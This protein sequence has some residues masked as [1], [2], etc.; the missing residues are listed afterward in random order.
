LNHCITQPLTTRATLRPVRSRFGR[1]EQFGAEKSLD[2]E[3]ERSDFYVLEIF[4][5]G[6]SK[7]SKIYFQK[8]SITVW[9]NSSPAHSR[10]I[11]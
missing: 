6:R 8:F 4:D 3:I 7:I 1:S 2:R 5:F 10:N 11:T 9:Q